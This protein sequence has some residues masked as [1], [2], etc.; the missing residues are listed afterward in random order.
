M[1][2]QLVWLQIG[3]LVVHEIDFCQG[4]AALQRLIEDFLAQAE[5]FVLGKAICVLTYDRDSDGTIQRTKALS[6][7]GILWAEYPPPIV[8]DVGRDGQAV[9]RSDALLHRTG[10]WW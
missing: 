9:G 1:R 4:R 8:L 10:N 6:P 2:G 7:D 3:Q 5:L